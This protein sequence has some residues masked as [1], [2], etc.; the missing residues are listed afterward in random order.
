MEIAG[1]TVSEID[2]CGIAIMDPRR[3][4]RR[5]TA[6]LAP[7]YVLGIGLEQLRRVRVS[8]VQRTRLTS[9]GRCA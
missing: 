9:P 7:R 4:E 1:N 2:P 6:A 8:G 5:V 3:G